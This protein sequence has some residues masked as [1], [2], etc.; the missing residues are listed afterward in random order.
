MLLTF[1]SKAAQEMCARLELSLSKDTVSK[2]K[3]GTFH[4]TALDFLRTCGRRVN[5]KSSSDLKALLKSIYEKYSLPNEA[6]RAD[7]LYELFSLYANTTLNDSFSAFLKNKEQE[8]FLD[9]YEH[10]LSE[11]KEAKR[12]HNYFDFNDILL[13]ARELLK[14]KDWPLQEVLVDEYQDTNNLQASLLDA[15]NAKSLFC[16][17]D[18]DQS[19]YAFN[20]ANIEIIASFSHRYP[21]AKIFA[22]NK[23]Y[24]SRPVILELANKVIE[25]NPRL[26]P[27]ALVAHKESN[28]CRPKL[29]EYLS[30]KAQYED[31]AKRIRESK[32]L[33]EEIAVIYRNNKSGDEI[34]AALKFLGI[35]TTRKGGT[36]FFQLRAVKTLLDLVFLPLHQNDVLAFLSLL[37]SAKLIPNALLKQI[38]EALYSLG[39][40]NIIKGL[41]SPNMNKK[42]D[43]LEEQKSKRGLFACEEE[44]KLFKS[45]QDFGKI[46]HKF[47]AHPLSKISAINNSQ[48]KFLDDLRYYLEYALREKSPF[49]L[50]NLA[51]RTKMFEHI[52][53]NFAKERSFRAGIFN[54]E[55]EAAAK[56]RMLGHVK[57]VQELAQKYKSLDEFYKMISLVN[58]SE[59]DKGGVNLLTVHSSKG[60]EF[61]QVYVIDLAQGRFPNEKL[62]ANAGGIEEERRLFYVAVTRASE[63]LFLSWAKEK[64]DDK[65]S[66][67]LQEAGF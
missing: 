45:R 23:N 8:D 46:S 58:E 61:A 49:H 37:Q 19:I 65:R 38:C 59:G 66:I 18:Y 67:F 11:F 41:L 24:R 7:Y 50:V 10:I 34:E 2:I 21:N 29:L 6:Y 48:A 16:V 9:S 14:D 31:I 42:I 64:P 51:A 12:R 35:K 5:I 20:G 44:E 55:L 56:E 33:A 52:I 36:S 54:K 22:L 28:D 40:R 62:S 25:K 1:T 39:D 15:L 27:K 53:N 3:A 26:F 60:L 4:A 13:E 17:G 30:A 63:E 32:F 43:I 57:K 47:L